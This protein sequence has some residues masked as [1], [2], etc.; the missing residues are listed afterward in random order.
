MTRTVE[1]PVA[2][3]V[4]PLSPTESIKD[5]TSLVTDPGTDWTVGM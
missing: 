5:V 4:V 3:T 1:A 2:P